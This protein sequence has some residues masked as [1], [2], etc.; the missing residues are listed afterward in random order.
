MS[1]DAIAYES[2]SRISVFKSLA[3]PFGKKEQDSSQ[4]WVFFL[5]RG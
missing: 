4:G 3:E 2:S 5:I 1:G